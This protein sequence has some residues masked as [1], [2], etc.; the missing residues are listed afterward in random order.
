MVVDERLNM[1]QE[2]ALAAQ[3]AN[4]IP[5]YTKKSV[6]IRAREV[7]LPLYSVLMR[8]MRPEML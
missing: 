7:I 3:K 2:C 4:C 8:P 5:G 1:S 6:T